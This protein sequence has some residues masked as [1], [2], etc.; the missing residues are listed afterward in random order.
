MICGMNAQPMSELC[1]ARKC[2][3]CI[4]PLCH[5]ECH[6]EPAFIR[7]RMPKPPGGFAVS[8]D[9]DSDETNEE[10]ALDFYASV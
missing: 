10:I 7:R 5:C 4:D 9:W 2:I 8:K 3:E 6:L 1:A